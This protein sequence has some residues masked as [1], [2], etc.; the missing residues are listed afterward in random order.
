MQLVRV[1]PI[2]V[3]KLKKTLESCEDRID[4]V[5]EHAEHHKKP[6]GID[7]EY[8]GYGDKQEGS[9]GEEKV[10][11]PEAQV[12]YDGHGANNDRSPACPHYLPQILQIH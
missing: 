2:F 10:A 7:A 5:V 9:G 3:K 6:I 4:E 1:E 11:D 8:G 12:V